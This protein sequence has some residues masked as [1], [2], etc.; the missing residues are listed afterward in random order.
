[1]D[2]PIL[3]VLHA[4]AADDALDAGVRAAASA[5]LLALLAPA[6]AHEEHAP[7][8]APAKKKRPSF[9]TALVRSN[10]EHDFGDALAAGGSKGKLA[11]LTRARAAEAR[12]LLKATLAGD[13]D[14][15][16]CVGR[17]LAFAGH[18][19]PADDD[20]VRAR[21]AAMDRGVEETARRKR[22]AAE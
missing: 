3:T 20:A 22:K 12:R 2:A 6:G 15:R 1:M 11:D 16:E 21:L 18:A 8:G 13:V 9:V 14:A 17:A 5:K 10:P 7:P 19:G 4:V